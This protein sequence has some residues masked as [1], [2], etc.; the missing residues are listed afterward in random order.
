MFVLILDLAILA[1]VGYAGYTAY[2]TYVERNNSVSPLDE[3]FAAFKKRLL[4]Q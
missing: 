3:Y 4:R 2:Q 1:G